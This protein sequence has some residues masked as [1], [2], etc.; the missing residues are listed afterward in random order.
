MLGELPRRND[1]RGASVHLRLK[2]AETEREGPIVAIAVC[3]EGCRVDTF[4]VSPHRAI[5]YVIAE[6]MR[7]TY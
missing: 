7:V 3:V 4:T 6:R 5:K 2:R 1:E